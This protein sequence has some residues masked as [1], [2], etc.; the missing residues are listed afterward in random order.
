LPGG[1]KFAPEL[2][3]IKSKKTIAFIALACGPAL[4]SPV[5]D[6]SISAGAPRGACV[7]R[8]WIMSASV[9]SSS[10]PYNYLQSLWQQQASS[11]SA[12]SDPLSQLFAALGQG[13]GSNSSSSS[14]GSTGSSGT[15][16]SSAGGPQFNPQMLQA[17][18]SLQANAADGS[19]SSGGQD[20]GGDSSDASDASGSSQQ[21]QQGGGHHH[22]HGGGGGI[23]SL[24]QMLDASTSG[25][26]TQAAANSNGSSTTTI[27]YSDGSSI[28]L[29]TAPS[30]T[31]SSSSSGSSGTGSS[32]NSSTAGAANVNMN[33]LL[34]QL[35]Q[36]QAQ[37]LNTTTPQSIAT[38]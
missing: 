10:N 36:M 38:A 4:A 6:G 3:G 34:E 9:N 26:T 17:L 23:E 20:G 27:D 1:G 2:A 15:T 30:S 7:S 28:S 14:T 25:A 33:N 35:I 32:D 5:P 22:H 8:S 13:S 18:F 21:A 24:L 37:L 29:T 19:Q 31:S 12:Q 11:T 16:A